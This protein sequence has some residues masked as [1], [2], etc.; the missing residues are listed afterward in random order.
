MGTKI[1]P[2]VEIF[3]YQLNG[4]VGMFLIPFIYSINDIFFEV[5]GKERTK[6]LARI[7]LIIVLTLVV[8]AIFAVK[9]PAA[10]R[11]ASQEPAYEAVFSQSIRISIASLMALAISNI[12]DIVI[13]AKLKL[14]LKK[15][16]LWFRNNISNLMALFL[17]TFIFMTLAFY[18]L[19]MSLAANTTFLLGLI[20]PY[21]LLKFVVSSCGT[22]LVYQGVKWLQK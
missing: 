16:G 15:Y 4:S 11:F 7:S 12:A 13:F 17:D 8:F 10:T 19:D 18:S 2:I 14:H 1:F 5:Y 6:E 22:P 3:G 20:L 21:W 9:L